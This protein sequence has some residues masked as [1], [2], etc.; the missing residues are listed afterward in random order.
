MPITHHIAAD[1]TLVNFHSPSV[2]AVIFHGPADWYVR[3][4]SDGLKRDCAVMTG[5]VHPDLIRRRA[6]LYIA[7]GLTTEVAVERACAIVAAGA[8]ATTEPAP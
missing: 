5:D 6:A 4:G 8:P 3:V 1:G 2:A 7:D